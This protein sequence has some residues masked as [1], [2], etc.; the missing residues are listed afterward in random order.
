MLTNI[1][2]LTIQRVMLVALFAL[3]FT[4]ALRIPVDTDTWWH[5]RSGEYTLEHGI[6]RED[7]F[8][9]TMRGEEW[10]NHSWGS[11]I[12]LYGLWKLAGDT[13]LALF[14]A[15]FATAGMIVLYFVCTG[16]PYMRA[17]VL[18]LGAATAAVF[19]SPR[20]HMLSFFLS[21][22]I[23]YLLFLYKRRG[24]DRLWFIPPVMLVWG[25]LHAGFSI[26][27]ILM[28]GVIAGEILGNLFNR[29][30][31]QVIPPSGIRKLL[32]VA[33][34]S[35]VALIVNPYFV[36]ILR[37]PFETVGIGALRRFIEE[38][39]SPNFQ[40]RQTWPFI[41][42][43]LGLLGA[44]GA[45]SRRL[46]W[47][48]FVLVSGTAFMALLYGRNIAV[49]AVVA[50]P[51]L[52]YHLDSILEERGWTLQPLRRVSARQAR[53]NAILVLGIIVGTLLNLISVLDPE[54]VDEAQR[55]HLPV[56]VAEFIAAERPNGPMFNS[57][58][59]GGYLM[60][61]LPDYPVYVDGRTDL[62]GNEFLTRY[63]QT[64]SGA[65]DWE[66]H[67]DED[68]INMVV[69]ESASGLARQLADEPGWT[70]IYPNDQH[71]DE[72]AMIYV[73]SDE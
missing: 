51:V 40:E 71:E 44:V 56:Q 9:H 3:I 32:I 34:V 12:I 48:N 5:I 29:G 67:L 66:E 39:N 30:G 14:T 20:P 17:F 24:V 1:R 4:M 64:A 63:L 18:I 54:F 57:Y 19:W 38:W 6:I 27:F 22:V 72:R 28:A 53:I 16:N 26:G 7:P 65:E 45:S 31:E 58:N 62:Y 70:R 10:I 25:N 69:I 15:L 35:V 41:A 59:W 52:A 68:G 46:D 37:V 13:G 50:T 55:E 33:L 73:R 49:F 36:D 21:T 60:F 2:Q 23:L 47:T 61:A 42:L 8:S 43:L 11:Q